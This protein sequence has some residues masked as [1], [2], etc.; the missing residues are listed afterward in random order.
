MLK[1][2]NVVRYVCSRPSSVQ[3]LLS[4]LTKK[5][6]FIYLVLLDLIY[7]PGILLGICQRVAKITHA[8]FNTLVYQSG[9]EKSEKLN[10][11]KSNDMSSTCCIILKACFNFHSEL[12]KW[13]CFDIFLL[14]WVNNFHNKRDIYLWSPNV[15]C[16]CEQS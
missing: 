15:T 13:F 9:G 4:E 14:I 7:I 10:N 8:L 5:N 3:E 6:L 11:L 12:N 1:I 16:I 2:W